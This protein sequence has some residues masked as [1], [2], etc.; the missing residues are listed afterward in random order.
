MKEKKYIE[1]KTSDVIDRDTDEGE[2]AWNDLISHHALPSVLRGRYL[3]VEY[4]CTF[5][6]DP[7][8]NLECFKEDFED[9]WK[10]EGMLGKVVADYILKKS[11]SFDDW[12][13]V[14]L[15]VD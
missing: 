13:T 11:P 15:L 9:D 12:S 10:F 3:L 8:E 7:Y 1:I 2:A 5:S 4:W 14:L 6:P